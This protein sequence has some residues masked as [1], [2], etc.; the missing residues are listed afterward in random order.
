MN[1]GMTFF[2][3]RDY[4]KIVFPFVTKV[5]MI[6]FCLFF[7]ENTRKCFDGFKASRAH[8]LIDSRMC[9]YDSP[10]GLSVSFTFFFVVLFTYQRVVVSF[11]ASLFC[12]PPISTD[13]ISSIRD[14]VRVPALVC[15]LPL[16]HMGITTDFALAIVLIRVLRVSVK[17]T[18]RQ[19]LTD[20]FAVGVC[21]AFTGFVGGCFALGRGCGMILLMMR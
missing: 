10:I 5:M 14:L 16:L 15:L 13:V 20:T 19:Q 21:A 9:I 12:L 4:V 17:F 7:A 8:S 1:V 6:F 18:Q 3:Q 2:A 11:F